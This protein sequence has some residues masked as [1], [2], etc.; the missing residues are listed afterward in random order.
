MQKNRRTIV[1]I[2]M[3]VVTAG[4]VWWILNRPNPDRDAIL[5]LLL[6]LESAAETGDADMFESGLTLDYGD[7]FGHDRETVTDRVMDKAADIGNLDV[8]LSN[9]EV[10]I[11]SESG[12]ATAKFRVELVGDGAQNDPDAEELRSRRRFVVSVRKEGP[13]WYVQRADVVYSMF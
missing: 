6:Q 9:I 13:S 1:V 10:D 8:Q 12:R 2:G 3:L 5:Q 7:R 11:D 4:V